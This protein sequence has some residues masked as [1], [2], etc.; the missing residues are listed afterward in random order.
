MPNM[1]DGDR[2]YMSRKEFR[3]WHREQKGS[4]LRTKISKALRARVFLEKGIACS[5]C[6]VS[7][8]WTLDHVKP[9]NKGGT[10]SFENLV[11]CCDS[12]NSSKGVNR[13]PAGVK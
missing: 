3:L 10:N 4:R 2:A 7:P 8:I 1:Y 9:V 5:Y 12:C 13:L 11:P 6:G